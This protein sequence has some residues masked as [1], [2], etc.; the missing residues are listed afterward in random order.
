MDISF[1]IVNY[2]G[3]EP[4]G[5]CLDSIQSLENIDVSWEVIVVDNASRDGMLEKF[6]V[7]YPAFH[8]IENE[9][10]YGFSYGNNLG[11]RHARGDFLFFLNPDTLITAAPATSML[12]LARQHPGWSI[13]SSQ[14][15]NAAG[16]KENP[17]GIFPSFWT[18]N[19]LVKTFYRLFTGK[20]SSGQCQREKIIFPDWVSG[21]VMLINRKVFELLGGW[22]EDFWL[23]SE[24]V[25][26]CKRAS[27]RG[28]QVALQCN[29]PITHRHGGT[30]RKNRSL[31]PFFKSHVIISR[32]IYFRKHFSGLHHFLLQSFLTVNSLVLEG[33][34][35]ALA[36]IIFY[37]AARLRKYFF[38]YIYLL[39][40]Y[41]HALLRGKW[42]IDT[43]NI[44]FPQ[45]KT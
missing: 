29:P 26:L 40:Y 36:G 44:I 43:K 20:S 4:L 10:N 18:I 7:R 11:A 15:V 21:S 33:L 25:D 16:K 17:F 45:G 41:W 27:D 34:L 3:W 5:A 13:V 35:P 1:I 22:D 23:Y 32:H 24:D 31:T 42:T 39:R 12:A 8:F 14:Q 9:G 30:T 6:R 19:G 2:K 28:G 37:P 38:L